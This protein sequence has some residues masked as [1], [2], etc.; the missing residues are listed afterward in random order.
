MATK[1]NSIIYLLGDIKIIKVVNNKCF[2]S[3]HSSFYSKI[4]TC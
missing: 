4:F 3:I 2:A 1:C